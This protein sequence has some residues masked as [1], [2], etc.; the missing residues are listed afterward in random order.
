MIVIRRTLSGKTYAIKIT[1]CK[2]IFR[3]F[4][5]A[6]EKLNTMDKLFLVFLLCAA[7][8]Q[9]SSLTMGGRIVGGHDAVPHSAPYMVSLRIAL[10]ES[11]VEP[12]HIC[13]GSILNANWVLTAGSCLLALPEDGEMV[14]YAGAH[15]FSEEPTATL[16]LRTIDE[17]IIHPDYVGG[18]TPYNIAMIRVSEPFVFNEFV[19]MIALPPKD[20][21]H[22][23]DATMFGWGN[24]SNTTTVNF[25]DILQ[26]GHNIIIFGKSSNLSLNFTD[27]YYAHC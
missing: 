10:N 23:G 15:D 21:I 16:Q 12:L 24:T 2:K 13:G 20:L 8:V 22:E 9:G 4:Q 1:F 27:C 19:Q 5:S 7:A 3:Q 26:V 11:D 14:V 6:R 25:P 18:A 17:Q